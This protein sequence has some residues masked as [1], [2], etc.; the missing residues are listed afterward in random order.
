MFEQSSP[1]AIVQQS[2]TDISVYRIVIDRAVQ[3]SISDSF[4][5][6]VE[7][8]HD[9]KSAQEFTA[10]YKLENDEYF[11][12]GNF[13]M[14]DVILDAIRS[15][16][17]AMP[18]S[19]MRVNDNGVLVI[20]DFRKKVIRTS[21]KAASAKLTAILSIQAKYFL[22]YRTPDDRAPS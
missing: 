10:S 14:P 15:P 20:A 2:K 21:P 8:M 3:K 16:L 22:M 4:S 12:I 11:K 18:Y 13:I 7:D 1:L 19:R 9:G 6:A 5:S 17:G